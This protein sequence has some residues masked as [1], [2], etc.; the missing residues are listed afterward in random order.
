MEIRFN[1]R[2]DRAEARMDRAEARMD[3]AEAR[4]DRAEKRMEK[5]DKRLE[6]TRKIVEVGMKLMVRLEQRDNILDAK[7][8]ALAESVRELTKSQKAFIDSLRKGGN[9]FKRIA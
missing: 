1:Q 6:A 3:R 7:L 4:M 2:M 5:F 8:E 9:G